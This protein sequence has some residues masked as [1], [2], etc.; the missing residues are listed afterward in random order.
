MADFDDFAQTL[1]EEAKRFLEKAKEDAN[2]GQVAYLHAAINLG[3]CALE[4]QVNGIADDF[5]TRTE[6]SPHDRSIL[7]EREVRL[8]DG[9]YQVSNTLKM[10]RLEDRIQFIHHRFSNTALDRGASWWSDLKSGLGLRNR[11]SHPKEAPAIKVTDV[12]R[13]LAAIIATVNALF[14]AVYKADYPAVG[15]GLDSRLNF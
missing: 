13:T 1:F 14:N 4:A 6:L 5:L 3:F 9:E 11:L 12:E 7:E 15:L 2:E 10:F 8:S